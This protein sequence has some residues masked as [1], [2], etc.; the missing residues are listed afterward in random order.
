MRRGWSMAVYGT[1][2]VVIL[3]VALALSQN[4]GTQSVSAS[5][6]DVH[7]SVYAELGKV[8]EKARARKNPM[9]TDPEAAVAGKKLFSQHCAECHG[10]DAGGSKKAPSLLSDEIQQATPGTLFW[11]LSNGV[12]RRGMPVWSRLPE[13]QRWQIVTHL[14]TLKPAVARP[15]VSESA[16]PVPSKAAQ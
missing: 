8:P 5:Q 7:S 15:A 9:E 12:V 1:P 11:I 4:A 2:A 13:P 14:K 3:G 16:E 10:S 6:A